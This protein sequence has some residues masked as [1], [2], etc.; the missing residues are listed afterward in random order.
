[1]VQL[2]FELQLA[3]GGGSSSSSS[4]GGGAAAAAA[5]AR[6]AAPRCPLRQDGSYPGHP[7]VRC[8]RT[9]LTTVRLRT[10]ALTLPHAVAA[11]D[12]L[13]QPWQRRMRPMYHH[14]PHMEKSGSGT[15]SDRIA[16]R[17]R[18]LLPVVNFLET[19]P[20]LYFSE[21]PWRALSAGTGLEAWSG[22]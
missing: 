21:S 2:Q 20:T 1:M 19:Y 11:A 4:S 13:A 10:L 15:R 17:T 12:A 16:R 5:V 22:R 7:P 14:V 3:S 18:M 8:Q 9:N 6:A